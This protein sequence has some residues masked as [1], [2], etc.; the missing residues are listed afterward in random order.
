MNYL[1]LSKRSGLGYG[2]TTDGKSAVVQMMRLSLEM[3][4]KQAMREV[5]ALR[6]WDTLML[7]LEKETE[8]VSFSNLRQIIRGE[9][10]FVQ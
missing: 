1:K 2:E 8:I 7:E 10:F 4:K 9:Y 3:I 5:R 6:E